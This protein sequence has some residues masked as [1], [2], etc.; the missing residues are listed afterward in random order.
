[1]S[2]WL[3]RSGHIAFDGER[4]VWLHG[5]EKSDF[6]AAVPLVRALQTRYQRL[7]YL[8]TCPDAEARDWLRAEYPNAVVTP[9]PWSLAYCVDR[10]LVNI[11][12]RC[13][14]LL[15]DV[16]SIDP[17]IPR[18]AKNREVP[19]VAVFA[20]RSAGKADDGLAWLG[21]CEHAFAASQ[22]AG[23][24]LVEAGLPDAAVTLAKLGD[25][26]G[27]AAMS[28]VVEPLL[29]RDL[30]I[31]RSKA[32]A[33]RRRLEAAAL[34]C[35]DQPRL[36]RLLAFKVQRVDTLEAL[37]ETLGR[38]ETILCLGNGP[39]S[40]SQ[41]LRDLKFD[42][43]FRVNHLW[44]KRGFLL[45]PDVVFTG[46]KASLA[47]VKGAIFGLQSIKSE[48]RLLVTRLLG[49]TT[50]SMRYMT[51]ERF[52]LFLFREEWRGVRPTN[53]AAMLAT[54]VA[55]QPKRL[56]VAGIDLFSHPAGSYPGDE[57]TP[58]A[59][60]PGH[61]AESE[62]ALLMQALDRYRGELVILSSALEENWRE[63]KSARGDEFRP[64]LRE[65]A[66]D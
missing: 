33:I 43:L 65:T 20:R 38:P 53:G 58:N 39:S 25:A 64:Q 30:K 36:C 62:L 1:M 8:F 42:S 16:E 63:F 54:A 52:D 56:V 15:G 12:V 7:D 18:R 44:L 46:S 21:A 14:L 3:I 31:L 28:A 34:W 24:A 45:R 57:K 23:R 50:G 2:G 17:V 11:N 41:E 48:S 29:M 35:M 6:Q 13:L 59:Y 4:T 47:V 5:T 26:A 19:T 61:A 60:S 22:D 49:F 37:N 9:P 51:L 55:L 32:R 40:E 10:F 27:V 66:G